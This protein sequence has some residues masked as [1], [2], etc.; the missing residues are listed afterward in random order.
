MLVSFAKEERVTASK[1]IQT[2]PVAGDIVKIT[3]EDLEAGLYAAKVV[4]YA[5]GLS[6]VQK[7]SADFGYGL[8]IAA[9]TRT[10]RGGCII[11]ADFLN[12]K[13]GLPQQRMRYSSAEWQARRDLTFTDF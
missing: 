9:C 3:V 12:E 1:V 6:L 7:A 5:Q 8:D 4:C 11:R 2:S 13:T 10:W